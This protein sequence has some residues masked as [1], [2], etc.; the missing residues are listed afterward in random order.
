MNWQSPKL[1][2]TSKTFTDHI[3]QINPKLGEW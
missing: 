1:T 2:E 3:K